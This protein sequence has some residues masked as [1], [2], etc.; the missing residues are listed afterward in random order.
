MESILLNCWFLY[1]LEMEEHF[2]EHFVELTD[3]LGMTH[4]W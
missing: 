1:W 3:M 4:H 2:V